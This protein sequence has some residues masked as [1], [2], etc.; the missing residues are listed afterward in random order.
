MP[1]RIS[2]LLAL[3]FE[4]MKLFLVIRPLVGSQWSCR[5]LVGENQD[6][7]PLNLAGWN[8]HI[9]L[10]QPRERRNFVLSG[11]EPQDAAG[12]VEDWIRQR[13]PTPPLVD[14]SQRDI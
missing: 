12:T 10:A 11:H 6:I 4:I 2:C 7:G 13:H 3:T 9:A 14:S 1:M 5:R 8:R